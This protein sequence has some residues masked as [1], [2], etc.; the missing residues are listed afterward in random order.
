MDA[1]EVSADTQ[2]EIIKPQLGG[3]PIGLTAAVEAGRCVLF[4]GAGVGGHA[5]DPA[6]QPAP[7][8]EALARDIAN[9]FGIDAETFE[10][11]TI[12]RVA[13]LRTSRADLERFLAER[14]A[15]LEPDDALQWLYALPWRAIFTTNY[16]SVIERAFELNPKPIRSPVV[17]S[18]SADMQA[19]D[20]RLDV[21]IYHLH[22][23]L[24]SD[25]KRRILITDE[26]YALF[27]EKRR[28]LF[29]VMKHELATAPILYMGYSHRDPNWKMLDAELRAEFAP[30]VPPRSYR[31]VPKTDPLQKELL[32]AQGVEAIDLG[33]SRFV[34]ELRASVG[35]ITL[36]QGGLQRLSE[37]VPSDLHEQFD[38]F[39]T[40]VARL[41]RGW[42]YVNQA[43]FDAAP[44]RGEFLAGDIANWALIGADIPFERDV[45]ETVLE[46][47]ID[48][49]TS[50]EER[51]RVHIVLGSAGYGVSTVLMRL[52][53]RL[54]REGAGRVF[55]HRE[56]LPLN[57]GDVLFAAEDSPAPVFF[58]VDNAADEGDRLASVVQRLRDRNLSACFLLGE[59]LNEWRQRRVRLN[60]K[61]FGIVALSD[62]EIERLLVYLADQNALN[63]LA[64]LTP[65]LRTAAIRE[66][67][68][69]QLL[70]AM[71]EATEGKAFD[72]IIE[73]EY[74]GIAGEFARRVY[75]S[76]CGFY[77]LRT[78]M[79]D[80]VL[81][82][83]VECGAA[84]LYQQLGEETAGI[85]MF[86]LLDEATGSYG[87]RARH[88]TIAEV[89]WE[90]VVEPGE[91]ESILLRALAALNLNYHV[92]YQA[93][94][95]LIRS[96]T[97][98]DGLLSL[99]GKIRFFEAAAQKDPMS[100]Y[101][102]Q[103]YARMLLREQ[104]SELAL[105]EIERAL[106]L[107]ENNRVLHHT[108]G[109]ILRHL[110][111]R[112]DSLEIARRRLVQSEAEFR[113]N[114][115]REP[116]DEYSYQSLAELYLGWSER[117]GS[118]D[119]VMNYVAKATEVVTEGLRAAR[120]RE[121]LHI[122]SASIE[123][124]LGNRP[125][126]LEALKRAVAAAPGS[127]VARYLLGRE[128]R[129]AG[130]L[131]EAAEVLRELLEGHPEEVGP[132]IHYAKA[133][134]ELG[135]PYSEAI[136]ALQLATLFGMRSPLYVSTL[137]GML[138]MNEEYTEAQRV[139]SQAQT[140]NFTFGERAAVN[141]QPK[142]RDRTTVQGTLT[143][144]GEVAVVKTGFAFI[145]VPGLPDIF[146]PGSKFGDLVMEPRLRVRF[147]LGF[148]A[149]G[150]I[151]LAP[152]AI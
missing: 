95:N 110:A 40:A 99:E 55:F 62:A 102:R 45:E 131:D 76:V 128:L 31:V 63:R 87:A 23:W 89:V 60:P 129:R 20:P 25:A 116:R 138:F 38:Q 15:G 17:I 147:K 19:F 97:T 44:N 130:K 65:A 139:F 32:D 135:R 150:P 81:A 73:D 140:Q 59:R 85:V 9:H 7:D 132:A 41:L 66:K 43:Q 61:E 26:D 29:E 57:E 33:V 84:D 46:D 42:T 27:H 68:E 39:P 18:A 146:C 36:D 16:D 93:F 24:D 51:T 114:I 72:A 109:V 47:L 71:R 152:S 98:V 69:K 35:E 2:L 80:S 8:G 37:N 78:V 21:P 14:L 100:P 143:L 49:A 119:E 13:E 133:L 149:R 6:G 105:A 117:A 54:V 64:D 127:V 83:V 112:T 107:D 120:S 58:V 77:R 91:R 145:K 50:P 86:D 67:H 94:E 22:G 96:D 137:G 144:E 79:R 118:E 70:V 124:A 125:Q 111:L 82:D 52:A 75:A 88:P 34:D 101:V 48:F 1:P 92:D 151:A 123:R 56:G 113:Q 30:S 122:V 4:V 90:R 141:Y 11:P 106:S 5:V 126:T 136:A 142:Y 12:S 103:H 28:M 104:R 53:T 108:K 115:S 10:L 148:T 134:E 3:L 121:G 74:R